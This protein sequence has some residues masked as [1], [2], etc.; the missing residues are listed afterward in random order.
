MSYTDLT[1][2]VLSFGI[3]HAGDNILVE[4]YFEYGDRTTLYI[5]DKKIELQSKKIEDLKLFKLSIKTVVI[6]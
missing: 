4:Y 6:R 5:L 1:S 2:Q 3:A